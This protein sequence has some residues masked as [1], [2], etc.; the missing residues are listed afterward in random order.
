MGWSHGDQGL[1]VAM[2]DDTASGVTE[3]F[4]AWESD[5]LLIDGHRIAFRRTAGRPGQAVLIFIHGITATVD[6]WPSMLTKTL[7]NTFQCI[8]LSLPGHF[9][10]QSPAEFTVEQVNAELFVNIVG[11]L[12]ARLP[13]SIN[14]HL[15]GWSTGGFQALLTSAAF[16]ERIRS[17]IS[18]CGFANGQWRGT[19][20]LLQLV[21]CRHPQSKLFSMIWR[22]V[23]RSLP[24]FA[25][26]IAQLNDGLPRSVAK[27]RKHATI[28]DMFHAFRQHDVRAV[29]TVMA[30][31]RRLKSG[32][33]LNQISCPVLVISGQ[34]DRI[35]VPAE[36]SQ[37]A[38]AIRNSHVGQL[39]S[40]GH[41]FF[42]THQDVVLKQIETWVVIQESAT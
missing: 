8:S 31:L 27:Y 11:Q 41:M 39:E 22:Q 4:A 16:P 40:M 7:I 38:D 19:L 5:E 18:I 30:G 24:I 34:Q 9:P 15:V 21:A 3:G 28:Q 35:I 33:A 29:Q 36:S 26:V 17:V 2:P 25:I 42:M 32:P 37:L 12:L 20:G 23:C 10:S 1:R 14:V 13:A 6:F